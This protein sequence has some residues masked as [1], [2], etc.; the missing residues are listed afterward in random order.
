MEQF[1]SKT[2]NAPYMNVIFGNFFSPA[3]D[4]EE[5]VDNTMRLIKE[6]GYSSVMFDTKVMGGF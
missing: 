3:Y 1:I 5:F 2:D 6:L 4:E